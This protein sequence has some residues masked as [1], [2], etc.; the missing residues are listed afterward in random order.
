MHDNTS[1]NMKATAP[2]S[3]ATRRTRKPRASSRYIPAPAN[4]MWPMPSHCSAA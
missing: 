3:A 4:Q 2:A 1:E